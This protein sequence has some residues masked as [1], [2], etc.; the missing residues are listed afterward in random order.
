M[1]WL[2]LPVLLVGVVLGFWLGARAAAEGVKPG[3]QQLARTQAYDRN[4]YLRILR[5]ELANHLMQRDPAMFE[6]LYEKLHY[7]IARYDTFSKDGLAGEFR[8]LVERFPQYDDFDLIGTRQH[9]LYPD[10]FGIHDDEDASEHFRAIVRFQA[11]NAKLDDAWS[12]F[13]ATSED[14]L[15]HLHDYARDV[16]DAKFKKRLKSAIDLFYFARGE[17]RDSFETRDFSVV[18]VSHIAEI[19]YGVHFKDTDEYG[20]YGSFHGDRAEPY[21]SYYRTNMMFED[22]TP[23]MGWRDIDYQ[24]PKK[25]FT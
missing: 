3:I 20:L 22:E 2:W 21:E 15:K 10:A 1:E 6:R 24:P 4:N 16:R 9:V 25:N 7:D 23:L 14:D 19:R 8:A 12:Q 17:D 5:R 13:K 11:L 18:R